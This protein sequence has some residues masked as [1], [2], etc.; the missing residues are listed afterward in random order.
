MSD[1]RNAADYV[2]AGGSLLGAS[3]ASDGL[4]AYDRKRRGMDGP[5]R[6]ATKRQFTRRHAGQ[7]GV[8]IAGRAAFAAGAPLAAYG[9]YKMVKPDGK[10]VPRLDARR[11]V[12]NP[13]TRGVTF[14]DLSDEQER[15]FTK[16][17]LTNKETT[18]LVARKK[19]GQKLSIAAGVMG[20]GALG[21][22]APEA[23]KFVARKVPKFSQMK[24]MGAVAAREPS[25]TKASN[26]L[27]IASIGVGAA[28]SLNYAAQQKLEAKA[29]KKSLYDGV[30][31]GIGRVRVIDRPKPGYV[32]LYD[33]RGV[34][35]FMAESRVTPVKKPKSK[36]LKP[37]VV[38]KP[39]PQQME[40]DFGKSNNDRF[41][42]E[43]G[44]RISPEAEKGY[45][46]LKRGRNARTADAAISGGFAGLSGGLGVHAL[47]RGSKGWAAV[48][49][50]GAALSSISA[51]RS[52]RDAARWNS[53]MGKIK[54]KGKERA[55]AGEYG[56]GR[57]VTK[58]SIQMSTNEKQGAALI[59][60][61]AGALAAGLSS[62]RAVSAYENARVRRI[63]RK[64]AKTP[65]A[66]SHKIRSELGRSRKKIL[67]NKS[68]FKT[69][70]GV[71][72][73]GYSLATPLIWGGAH[74]FVE[75]AD[76]NDVNAFMGGAL[77]G[78]G[79]YQGAG[80]MTQLTG[81][82]KRN[83]AGFSQRAKDTIR[84]HDKATL[85][86][87][88]RT[89][90]PSKGNPAWKKHGRTYPK[91]DAQMRL[92]PVSIPAHKY[93]RTMSRLQGGKTQVA[94]TSGVAGL[95]GLATA[96]VNRK[97]RSMNEGDSVNKSA[98]FLKKIRFAPST[99]GVKNAAKQAREA[100][101]RADGYRVGPKSES[102]RQTALAASEAGFTRSAQEGSK[103]RLKSMAAGAG[104][105]AAATAAG[106]TGVAV[107][108]R[109]DVEKAFGIRTGR[110]VRTPRLRK[111]S[112]RGSYIST[113]VAGK[114]FTVRGSVR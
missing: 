44:N 45:K 93:K 82:E 41:L 23:A 65:L 109:K 27:G 36:K 52:G 2:V 98:G 114:K 92:G 29:V 51:A 28:G 14:K 59:A 66:A 68:G 11:D 67:N 50:A 26:A 90:N 58:A 99:K 13:V 6:A 43:Y 100:R 61:G 34:K 25:A 30:V 83:Y 9:G 84:A 104:Y 7:V 94:I 71:L 18:K 31:R 24:G 81:W 19:R 86:S 111:P 22:R 20:L 33:D 112:I 110:L 105:G 53:K 95:T 107:S 73:G 49:G 4:V 69:R 85:R 102:M 12:V 64:I 72:I 3:A 21:L 17:D 96:K 8:K 47:K 75:K 78:A 103:L 38:D 80:Y 101:M 55:A 40:M 56:N 16:A 37:V 54:A 63:D 5:I 91:T 46:Y 35:R 77:V 62:G 76:G 57:L 79:A 87:D 89:T 88:G 108:R 106:A 15:R 32:N 48:G 60:T 42:R 1:R 70:A 10:P 39:G 97:G 113:S 74:K